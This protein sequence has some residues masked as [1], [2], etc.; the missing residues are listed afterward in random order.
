MARYFVEKITRKTAKGNLYRCRVRE[1]YLGKSI[2]DKSKSFK[3]KR[4]AEGWGQREVGKIE[5]AK[6][7]G[8]LPHN[9]TIGDL[10][11]MALEDSSMNS[12]R[13][14]FSNL[15]QLLNYPLSF[16]SLNDFNE[17]HL[18]QH[19]KH[20]IEIDGIKPQTNAVEISNLRSIFKAAK[21]IWGMTINDHIFKQAHPTLV[22][23]KLITKSARRSRRPTQEEIKRLHNALS[24]LEQSPKCC[25]PYSTLF[26][27]SILTCMRIGEICS[28]RWEDVNEIQRAVRVRDRKDPRKKE[29]NHQWA[30]LL[31]D[32]WDILQR[33]PKDGDLIFPYNSRSVT[34]GFR[35]TRK[36]LGIEDLRYHDLRR[37][38]ASR[39]FEAGF[40]I[41]EVAQVTGHRSL[42]I[43]WQVYTE[44]YPNSLQGKKV[45][46]VL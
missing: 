39:L 25:I 27:F 12:K 14:K 6:D 46:S 2:I 43:L 8:Y 24:E 37:E 21:A 45:K 30:P 3:T 1:R 4:E 10:I 29:G 9:E 41:E 5:G 17:N 40:T 22:Y 11:E 31:G 34:A 42:N 19:C 7:G 44:L 16:V 36:E 23:M 18:I 15:R 13:T 32:A 33:Q 26:E 20:R 35:R 38:G 28:I